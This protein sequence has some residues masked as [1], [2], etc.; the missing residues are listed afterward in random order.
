MKFMSGDEHD[1]GRIGWQVINMFE[2][3]HCVTTGKNQGTSDISNVVLGEKLKKKKKLSK[4]LPL[5]NHVLL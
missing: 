3:G 4:S 5:S 2:G 1:E